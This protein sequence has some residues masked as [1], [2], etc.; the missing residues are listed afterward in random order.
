MRRCRRKLSGLRKLSSRPIY[1]A[2]LVF[3]ATDQPAV[4]SAVVRAAQ[5]RKVLVC[6]ADADEQEAGDFIV[7]A[8]LRRGPIVISVAAGSPALSGKVRDQL[9]IAL[10]TLHRYTQLAEALKSLRPAL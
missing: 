5:E 1:E 4:N 9:G 10:Q 7:P 2:T 8:V 6:R 3:A